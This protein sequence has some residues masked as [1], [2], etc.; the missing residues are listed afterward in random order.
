MESPLGH[1]AGCGAGRTVQGEPAQTGIL[2]GARVIWLSRSAA[3]SAAPVLFS[4]PA[5]R[6]CASLDC[7]ATFSASIPETSYEIYLLQ[8]GSDRGIFSCPSIAGN[9]DVFP[10]PAFQEFREC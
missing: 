8:A 6:S 5:L 7:R 2:G 9:N 4:G 10:K 3:L 1:V